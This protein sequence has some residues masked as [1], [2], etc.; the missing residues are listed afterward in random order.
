[1]DLTTEIKLTELVQINDFK[2]KSTLSRML[3][4]T[5]NQEDLTIRNNRIVGISPELAEALTVEKFPLL[6]K[7][8]IT[9]L[10]NCCGGVGKT[11]ST[12]NLGM[13]ARRLTSRKR[14]QIYIDCDPQATLSIQL[15]GSVAEGK[16][17]VDY[18]DGRASLDEIIS[19][20]SIEDNIFIIKSNLN[21]IYLDKS[22]SSVQKIKSGMLLLLQDIEKSYPNGFRIFIDTAPQLSSTLTST[23]IAL[24]EIKSEKTITRLMIPIRSDATSINGTRIV[25]SEIESALSAF[26]IS[27][28]KLKIISFFSALDNRIKK[29]TGEIYKMAITSADIASTLSPVAIKYSSEIVKSNLNQTTLFSPKNDKTKAIQ[30]EFTDLFLDSI[31]E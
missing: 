7:N 12:I 22:F 9:V 23:V 27:S 31:K 28:D 24:T 21:N 11:S 10:S 30:Q 16:T 26:N 8:S 3:S 19:P 29:T 14:I 18:I 2:N 17:L 20:L 4:K 13:A 1:M 15:T 5:E 25:K 6:L